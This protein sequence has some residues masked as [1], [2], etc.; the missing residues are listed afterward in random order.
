MRQLKLSFTLI[1]LAGLVGCGSNGSKS[2]NS[3]IY[4]G[5][6]YGNGGGIGGVGGAGSAGAAVGNDSQ[7]RFQLGLQFAAINGNLQQGQV[8]AVG[9][10]IVTQPIQ[11]LGVVIPPNR[12]QLATGTPGVMDQFGLVQNLLVGANMGTGAT[13]EILVQ[14]ARIQ[15]LVPQIRTCS[16][17]QGFNELFGQVTIN[18]RINGQIACAL[19][20]YI[21]IQGA[22]QVCGI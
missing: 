2:N 7:G 5:Y 8:T 14:S 18:F 20:S 3:G 1:L 21:A 16:G 22:P 12:Y 6:G 10:L 15:N 9:E 19:P 11:C 13:L 17:A 4:G